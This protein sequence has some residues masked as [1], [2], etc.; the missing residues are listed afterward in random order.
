MKLVY[1][2]SHYIL[3]TIR[4]RDARTYNSDCIFC[5][6]WPYMWRSH[7]ARDF[8][9]EWGS[10]RLT[11]IICPRILQT[12]NLDTCK[13]QQKNHSSH[14]LAGMGIFMP[15]LWQHIHNSSC[16]PLAYETKL[17]WP[18]HSVSIEKPFG[19]NIVGWVLKWW[20]TKESGNYIKGRIKNA[21]VNLWWK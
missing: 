2:F 9:L 4:L 1:M 17:W 19:L 6:Q 13:N 16:L 8:H 15:K 20:I 5:T 18:D 7:T 3:V 10:L 21:L 14:I 12:W 11:P